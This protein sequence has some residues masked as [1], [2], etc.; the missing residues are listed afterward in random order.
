[1]GGE[2]A[3][4]SDSRVSV[5]NYCHAEIIASP[6]VIKNIG[7]L[8][9]AENRKQRLALNRLRNHFHWD[10]WAINPSGFSRPHHEID[11]V[12]RSTIHL[13]F[14]RSAEVCQKLNLAATEH[15]SSGTIPSVLKL[16]ANYEING[17][18]VRPDTI[19]KGCAA[20]SDVCL[21][22]QS[23]HFLRN[24]DGA[25]SGLIGLSG[26]LQRNAPAGAV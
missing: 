15:D 4:V 1:M 3:I 14:Y 5:K 20:E 6:D 7:E 9:P 11:S 25:D 12:P 16:R 17:V 24:F 21:R 19:V 22:L 13:E 2:A 8:N 23:A 26:E 18:A 10:D